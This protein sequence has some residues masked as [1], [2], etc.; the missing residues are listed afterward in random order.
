MK[1]KGFTIIELIVVIAIIAVLTSIVAA[2]VGKYTAN[3]KKALVQSSVRS[4][5]VAS[6]AY[7]DSIPSSWT[8]YYAFCLSNGYGSKAIEICNSVLKNGYRFVCVDGDGST[9]SVGGTCTGG[10]SWNSAASMCYSKG[11]WFGFV[12]DPNDSS[13]C[14]CSD[15]SGAVKGT[16]SQFTTSGT[17]N[18]ACQ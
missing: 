2:S 18:C 17:N 5:R 16:L 6:L 13:E 10:G 11:K 14:Y 12:C 1:Q 9:D 4:L 8:P 15:V 3:A 7:N